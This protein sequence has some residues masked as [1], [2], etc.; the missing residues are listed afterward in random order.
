[1]KK[2]EF[3]NKIR[4]SNM[5]QLYRFFVLAVLLNLCLSFPGSVLSQSRLPTW[6]APEILSNG[7]WQ[8]LTVDRRGAVHVTWHAGI[9]QNPGDSPENDEDLLMY[10]TRPFD[11]TWSKPVDVVYA[12]HGGFTVRNAVAVSQEGILSVLFRSRTDHMF[13]QSPVVGATDAKNWSSPRLL[14]SNAYYLDLFIDRDDVLHAVSSALN[15]PTTNAEI[16]ACVG[17]GDIIYRRSTDGGKNW[18]LPVNLSNLASGADKPDIWQGPS[19]RLYISWDSGFDWYVSRGAAYDVRIVYSN[20]G[21]LT[22]SKPISLPGEHIG[23]IRPVQIAAT[24]LPNGDLMAVWRYV[25][26]DTNIYYQISSDVGETWSKPEP[27]PDIVGL[28]WSTTV[29]DDYDLVLDKLGNPQLFVTG[30]SPSRSRDDPPGIYHIEYRQ[31]RWRSPQLI[32]R[33]DNNLPIWPKAAVGPK[34]DI[35]LTWF[36]YQSEEGTDTLSLHVYYTYRSPTLPDE[37]LEDFNPTAIPPTI[38]AFTSPLEPTP[39]PYPTVEPLEPGFRTS[40]SD[41]YATRTLLGAVFVVAILCFGV[42]VLSGF[43]LRRP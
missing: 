16:G 8:N 27:I 32:F 6:S 36:V 2:F 17:C 4:L 20:D 10:A 41:L 23:R 14:T 38:A 42:L 25:D 33:A 31:G 3:A 5:R 7:W 9:R 40:T 22:W 24:E 1:M 12:A 26:V 13:V 29:L 43:R 28:D 37:Q 39:T 35:H 21:G 15:V 30:W 11:G 34:N 19:G 18:S